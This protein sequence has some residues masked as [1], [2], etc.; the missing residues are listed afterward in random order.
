M[1]SPAIKTFK[2]AQKFLLGLPKSGGVV[3]R[4]GFGLARARLLFELLGNPEEACA[5]IHIA[6]TS[7][8]GSIAYTTEALLRA[9]NKTTG[10]LL[11][12][13]VADVRERMQING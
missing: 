8:K 12:P 13:H 9:A 6:G 4:A 7:G 11:S 2:D 10:L 3:F 5:V 1:K